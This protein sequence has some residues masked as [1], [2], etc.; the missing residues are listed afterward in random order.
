[1]KA[2][3]VLTA[4]A[5][6]ATLLLA[7]CSTDEESTKET[8][9]VEAAENEKVYDVN[10][11][12]ID[13]TTKESDSNKKPNGSGDYESKNDPRLMIPDGYEAFTK[14][15]ENYELPEKGRL[16]QEEAEE[17]FGIEFNEN[18]P[19]IAYENGMIFDKNTKELVSQ[20]HLNGERP[21]PYGTQVL[22]F[23]KTI[24]ETTISDLYM[25]K[26]GQGVEMKPLDEFSKSER[27]YISE[28]HGWDI[29]KQKNEYALKQFRQFETYFH[30][31]KY[32]G[33]ASWTSET[34]DHLEKADSMKRSNWEAAYKHFYKAV[35][36]ISDMDQS[37]PNQYTN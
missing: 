22:G 10:G 37:I 15:L 2:K 29:V 7:A 18:F 23:F 26:E 27:E 1:M 32:D 31:N 19:K 35:R 20:V 33:L 8:E 14:R 25:M 3:K 36:R 16:S 17:L 6:G 5:L 21:Y 13:E 9:K 11:E 30:E 12:V 34:V 24:V 28:Q 4:A